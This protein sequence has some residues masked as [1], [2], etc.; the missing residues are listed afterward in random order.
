MKLLKLSICLFLWQ[1]ASPALHTK[2]G[3]EIIIPNLNSMDGQVGIL[4]FQEKDGYPDQFEQALESML[5]PIDKI[6]FSI[7]I[8]N[9]LP[10]KYVITVM[11]DKNGNGKLDKNLF[12]IPKEGYG[13]S[14]NPSSQ[15]FG[16]PKWEE[17]LIHLTQDQLKIEVQMKYND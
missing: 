1:A 6:P 7:G 8:D 10:G 14:N 3:I 17:G 12:G 11:H 15:K 16:P 2:S 9:L 5:V 13:V 4:V